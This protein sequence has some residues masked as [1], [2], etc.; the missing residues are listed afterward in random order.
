MTG[1]PSAGL[2]PAGTATGTVLILRAL[3][4][5][6]T[7]TG[8]AALRGMRR[9]WPSSRL[10]LAGPAHY[11]GWLRELGIVDE[12]L[13][14][15]GLAPLD[16]PVGATGHVAVNLHG[17]GPQSHR[18]L[19]ATRP[20]RLLAFRCGAAGHD[21]GPDWSWD[22]H[23]VDRWCRLVTAAGGRC[24]PDDLR[25]PRLAALHDEIV[26][27]PGAAAGSRR[28]PVPRWRAVVQAL[29]RDGGRVVVT[30]GP[31]ERERCARVTAGQRGV[32]DLAG[33][34]SVASLADLVAGAP[35]LISG[36]TGA[37]HLATAY[38]T[39]SVLLFGP[40]APELWGPALDP[41][42]H[43][44]LWHGDRAAIGDPHATDIDPALAAITIGEVLCAVRAQLATTPRTSQLPGDSHAPA[45]ALP[46]LTHHRPPDFGSPD[47]RSVT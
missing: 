24:G 25:L 13:P 38:G 45:F 34:L 20:A 22:E 21:E 40:T 47:H 16:W 41:E 11:S 42:L 12:V 29:V 36:D 28:W 10:V 39:P 18:L 27:H 3:G 17:C 33:R 14:A 44:V 43:T 5:G 19:Q 32:R 31:E 4:L 23:E 35:L 46:A 15:R 30:G 9:A 7:L 26:V 8:I 6:D 37:A 1:R 2:R